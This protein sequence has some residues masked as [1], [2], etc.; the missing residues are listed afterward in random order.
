VRVGA[1]EDVDRVPDE[2]KRGHREDKAAQ[3]GSQFGELRTGLDLEILFGSG[4][5]RLLASLELSGACEPSESH[6]TKARF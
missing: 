2:E 4:H 1:E 6:V 3:L 5:G